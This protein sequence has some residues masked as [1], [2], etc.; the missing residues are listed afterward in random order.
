[1]IRAVTFLPAVVLC[2][3]A[4]NAGCSDVSSPDLVTTRLALTLPE[5]STIASVA[6]TV[7]SSTSATI[8]AGNIAVSDTNAVLSLDLVLGPGMGDVVELLAT[9]STGASC[10]GTSAPFDV[11]AGRSTFINLTLV[12]GGDQPSSGNCPDVQSW[13]VTPVQAAAPDGT[14][15]ASVVATDPDTTQTLSYSWVATAGTFGDP[16]AAST[17]YTCSTVGSQTLT[18]TVRNGPFSSSGC[19]ATATFLVDCVSPADAGAPPP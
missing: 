15:G 7:L 6:Y 13:A 4:V 1:M 10:A 17:T 14:I 5:G 9:T 2:A 19:A 11:V 12:C 18:L 8:A 16:S 3:G